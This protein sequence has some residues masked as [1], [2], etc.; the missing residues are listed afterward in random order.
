MIHHGIRNWTFRLLRT[1]ALSAAALLA[2]TC[3]QAQ[4]SVAAFY[5]GRTISLTIAYPP[6][7]SYDIYSRLAAAHMGKYI[8]GRPNFVV[9]NKPGGIGVMRSFYETAPKDGSTIGIFPETIAIMAASVAA[10]RGS[11]PDSGT[12]TPRMTAARAESGPST[13]MRLGPNNA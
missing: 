7:G 10:R 3:A 5:R 2:S 6:G 8:P 13:R 1:V 4:D 9:Q 11:P 12:T